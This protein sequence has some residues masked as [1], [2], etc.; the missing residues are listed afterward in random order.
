MWCNDGTIT[1]TATG[2]QALPIA[3]GIEYSINGGTSWLANN[4]IFTGLAGGTYNIM[5]RNADDNCPVTGSIITLVA[6]TVPVIANVASTNITDCGSTNGTI[7]ITASGSGSLEYS[8]N[9]GTTYQPSNVFSNLAAGTYQIR[10]RNI[11]G[12]CMVTGTPVTITEPTQPTIT[13]VTPQNPSNCGVD[14]GE[15]VIVATAGTGATQYS[16]NGGANWSNSGTFTGLASGTYNIAIRNSNAT[17]EVSYIN[18]PV[19]LVAPNAASITNVASTHPSNCGLTDGS[20]TITATGGNGPLQYSIDGSTWT[21]TTGSFTNLPAGTYT[22][23]VR[24]N[25]GSCQVTGSIITL[26]APVAPVIDNVASANISDCGVTDGSITITATGG[27]GNYQ[28]SINGGTTWVQAGSF[29][30]LA[31]GTY[32]IAVRNL[33]GTCVVT[34]AN[35]VL[36]APVAPVITNVNP[37]NPTNCGLSDGTITITAT[38][39]SLEYSIN[40]GLTW[41]ANGGSFTG[42]ASGSYYV[43]VRNT[44]ETCEVLYTSNPVILT[45]PNAPSITNVSSTQP[46]N[47]GV[48][49]GTITITATG[50]SGSYEYSI[51]GTDWTNTTGIFTGLAGGT[52]TAHVRNAADNSCEV[53]GQVV[54]LIDKVAPTITNVASTNITNCGVTDGTITI[55]ANGSGTLQ[56]SIDGGATWSQS[57]SF[58]GLTAGTYPIRVRNIDGTCVVTNPNVIITAPTQPVVNTVTP[59]NPT[60]CGI[61]DGIITVSAT[62]AGAVQYS[63]DG[64]INWSNTGTFN[65]LSAGTYNI[66]VRNAGGTC[67]VLYTSNPVIL[68]AP[69][70]ASITNVASTNPTN[71]ATADGTITVTASGGIAPLEYSIDGGTTWQVSNTFSGLDASGNPYQIRVRNNGGACVVT[72]QVVNLTDK[73]APTIATVASTNVTDCGVADGTITITASGTGSLQYSIN[74]GT[75]WQASDVFDNLAAGTYQIRVRNIDGTCMVSSANVVITAPSQP[76]I[77]SVTPANP[78]DCNSTNGTIT[79]TAIP[80]PIG[81]GL[82]YSING[83]LTWQATGNFTNLGAGSYFV[84][85]RNIGGTCQ[86]LDAGNPVILTVPNAPSITNVASA[87]PTNCGLANGSITITASGGTAPLEY[88]I[89]GGTTWAANG[90]SFTGLAGGTYN[91]MVRNDGGTCQV[92]GSVVVLT[93]KVAPTISAVASTNVTDCGLADGTITITASGTG[94]LQYSINGGTTWQASDVFDN[95]AAGTYQIRVRNIDQTC[96][97]SS[98]NVTITAPTAPIVNNVAPMN[99][100]NCGVNDGEIVVTATGAN[101]QYSIDGGTNWQASNSFNNLAAGTYNVVVRNAAGGTCEVFSIDNP[102]ILT[103]PN[104]PSITTVASANPTDCGSADGTITITATGGIAPLEYSINGGATW[105]PSNTFTALSGGT[106]QIRVSNAGNTC[107]VTYPNVTLTD[108]VLPIIANVTHTDITDCN[109][110]DGTITITASSAQGAVEYSIDGG[111]TWS[112]SGTFIGL[113]AGSYVPITRNIDGTCEVMAAAVIIDAPVEPIITNVTPTNPSN[114]GVNDGQI[115]ITATGTSLQYSINGVTWQASNTFASLAA[116]TYNVFVRNTGGTCEVTYASNPVV[117]T[118]PNA[119]SITNVASANPTDCGSADGTITITATGG[120]GSFEYSINGGTTWTNTT[121]SFTG[122]SGGTYQIRVRNAA[123]NSCPVTYPNVILIDKVAPVIASVVATNVSNCGVTDGTITIT[124]SSA[125]GAVQYSIGG[126]FQQSGTFN[127]LPAGTYPITVQNIDGTCQVTATAVIITAPVAPTNIVVTPT[128]P[129]DCGISDGTITVTATG[130]SLQYSIDGGINWSNSGSFTGLAIGTYNVF[131]RNTN[132]TCQTANPTNPV[133]L[134]VPNAP[135]ITSVNATNPTDC[136]LTDGT[137]TITATGGTAPLEYSIDGGANWVANGGTFTALAGG[138]YNTMVRNAGG[139][140]QVTGQIVTLTNKVAPVITNVSRTNPTNCNVQDG[141][142]IITASSAQGSVEYSIDGGTTWQPSNVFSGLAAGT[143]NP[144]V[145]NIDGTCDVTAAPVI[146][147]APV[148]PIIDDVVF[149]SPTNCNS[150]NGQI[151]IAATFNPTPGVQFSIDGG[152][153]WQASNT[154]SGLSA[155]TYNVAVRNIGGTCQVLYTSNPVILTTP[156]APTITNVASSNPTDCNLIDGT[157]TITATGTGA[158]NYSINGGTT[159][160]NNG[161][162]YTGLPAGTYN[163]AVRNADGTCAVTGQVVILTDKI[164]P[165]IANTASTD[166]TDCG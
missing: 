143:Y 47:C 107:I 159:W 100:S 80:M 16:I 15:I 135:S 48:N 32:Q 145:R 113:T 157:I 147:T 108:K 13:S 163:I 51:N 76:V 124:A 118:A 6:P 58:T 127:G 30:G 162:T 37:T 149:T 62:G 99:P 117:L 70:A 23:S 7:T 50:G 1:I 164:A 90:G 158:L 43:S 78:T 119:P 29:T 101:L 77:T 94:S 106:Y 134:S 146:I 57:G 95:L 91:I 114:C 128:D 116:G 96:V 161:G 82:E 64:G 89:N 46:T 36:T 84:A 21:N 35:V 138:T 40:G 141:T 8:I 63:I 25:D 14:D 55:T 65:G 83:G 129:T 105:Q 60:N 19:V 123:D 166:P 52:Y 165:V 33:N 2:G 61:N 136:G 152:I 153:N 71:C 139:S 121:G 98:A 79:V 85:V 9:G 59:T 140:C 112:Q 66:S 45:A 49:D 10:V 54:T 69:N 111:T 42:L 18:N 12:S 155:G 4:G 41:F 74:G 110:T 131:V 122:L 150:N 28:Y 34:S 102:I 3:I 109:T 26:I 56:Y 73:V 130:T 24:N 88:S 87:N 39:T 68:T 93:D 38:G 31:A 133:I 154:F 142:I 104:A 120:S 92:T 81:T 160:Q 156:N 125:Q 103:A 53:T 5:V 144:V 115:V 126:A 17:C 148:A 132:G 20:I 27:S 75:T 97:V 137:I 22:V 151:S 11:N 44:D 67:P 72:G 86:V